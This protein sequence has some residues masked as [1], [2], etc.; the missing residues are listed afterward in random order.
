MDQSN[1]NDAAAVLWC[2]NRLMRRPEERKILLVLSDGH[3]A[4]HNVRNPQEALIHVV[5]GIE[6]DPRVELMGL[7]ITCDAVKRYY[8][9]SVVV[10]KA[11]DMSTALID[12]I[13]NKMLA[14]S[15]RS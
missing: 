8:T 3:P 1:N 7:G 4:T 6:A 9:Q 10:H 15:K 14:D 5:K 11:P 2:Y 12:L 13:A